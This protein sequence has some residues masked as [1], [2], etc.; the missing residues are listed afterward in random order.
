MISGKTS[1]VRR[2][3]LRHVPPWFET[4]I[5]SIPLSAASIASSCVRMPLRH[6][7]IRTVSRRRLIESQ[8]RFGDVKPGAV[9]K[10]NAVEI[11]P[12]VKKS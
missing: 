6:D 2:R 8:V 11:R 10:V 7:F 3:C 1:I 9:A 5:P 12:S 4:M